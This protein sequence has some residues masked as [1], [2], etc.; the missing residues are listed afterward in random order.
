MHVGRAAGKKEREALPCQARHEEAAAALLRT[1]PRLPPAGGN[2]RAP[3][4]PPKQARGAST[5]PLRRGPLQRPLPTRPR[6]QAKQ[7]AAR[8]CFE[9]RGGGG[10]RARLRS[11]SLQLRRPAGTVARAASEPA[12]PSAEGPADAAPAAAV[13]HLPSGVL[14]FHL[15]KLRAPLLLPAPSVRNQGREGGSSGACVVVVAE[16][17]LRALEGSLEAAEASWEGRQEETPAC[18]GR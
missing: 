17:P 4:L 2:R 9:G 5:R 1:A 11:A 10:A 8:R 13:T 14:R 6:A 7:P 15:P 12:A 3:R 16:L 18:G